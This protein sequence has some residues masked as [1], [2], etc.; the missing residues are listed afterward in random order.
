MV[1]VK[2]RMV[3]MGISRLLIL[4]FQPSLKGRGSSGLVTLRL[5][6]EAWANIKAN[7]EPTA[8]SAP[9]FLK[10]SA[11]NNPGV[12]TRMA[13][14]LNI[15]IEMKG[16]LNRGC[17]RLSTGGISLWLPSEKASLE[18]PMSPALVA[19]SKIVPANM[20]ISG[21]RIVRNNSSGRW[22]AMPATGSR[23][24]SEAML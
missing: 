24:H 4:I 9:M 2:P 18:I 10:T 5:M 7:K 3:L 1:V 8:Y 13:T 21:L 23:D 19:M 14:T 12:K 17:I 22:V 16:V 15:I 6:M 11:A 20:A